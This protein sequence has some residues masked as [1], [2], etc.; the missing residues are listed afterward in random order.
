MHTLYYQYKVTQTFV[1]IFLGGGGGGLVVGWRWCGSIICLYI[2]IMFR[3]H[4][5]YTFKDLSHLDHSILNITIQKP[6]IWLLCV[7]IS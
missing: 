3:F 2:E 6:L 4:H 7:P 1:A 5:N